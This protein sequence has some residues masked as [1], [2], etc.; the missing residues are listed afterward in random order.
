MEKKKHIALLKKENKGNYKESNENIFKLIFSTFNNDSSNPE[1]TIRALESE[2]KTLDNLACTLFL[3]VLEL[4]KER[5]R[6]ILSRTCM[7]QLRNIIGYL[8]SAYCIYRMYA[9]TKSL[10]FGE[11]F[12]S[13]PVTIILGII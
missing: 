8:L 7:G 12:S 11:D 4:K 2:V 1:S 5:K 10:V 13:E 3:E 9:S 6:A